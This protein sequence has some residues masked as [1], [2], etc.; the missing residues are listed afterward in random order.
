MA[1]EGSIRITFTK[2]EPIWKCKYEE[3]AD[4]WVK[5]RVADTEM[6]DLKERDGSIP[7]EKTD[8]REEILEESAAARMSRSIWANISGGER[9]SLCNSLGFYIANDNDR[10]ATYWF[11]MGRYWAGLGLGLRPWTEI[12]ETIFF[13][14]RHIWD[15]IEVE[16]TQI[17]K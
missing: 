6:A 11:N 10:V 14:L 15:G 4:L 1:Q 9:V 2:D 13:F 8:G 3:L 5:L 17:I 16:E 7:W 12:F